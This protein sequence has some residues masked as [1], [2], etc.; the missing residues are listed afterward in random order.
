MEIYSK[1]IKHGYLENAFGFL[2]TQFTKENKPNRSFHIA[3][4]NLPKKTKSL[5]LTFIDYDAVPV[6][7]FPWIHWTVSNIN[8]LL[9]ELPEDASEKM[10]LLEG[11]TSWF[12]P[13]LPTE[14]KLDK[15]Q[16]IGYGGCAPPDKPH[17]YTLTVY[18]LNTKLSLN[19]GF[20]LNE[21]L[22]AMEDHILDHSLIHAIYKNK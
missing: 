2:G 6:C 12:S 8:P 7:G 15:E 21:L 19:K 3:W 22:K 10:N 11:I 17:Q 14:I 20:Y 1:N 16:A 13:L 4:D 9:L 18:A 5:V